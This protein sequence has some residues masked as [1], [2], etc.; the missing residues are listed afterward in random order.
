MPYPEVWIGSAGNGVR[1]SR[2]FS[3]ES[4]L[5]TASRPER[6][7]LNILAVYLAWLQLGEPADPPTSAWATRP[8]DDADAAAFERLASYIRAWRAV[9]TITPADLGR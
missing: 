6:V 4:S 5:G 8:L 7:A 9:G 2:R 1:A 3:P